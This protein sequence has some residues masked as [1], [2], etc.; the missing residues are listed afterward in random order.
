MT[1]LWLKKCQKVPHLVLDKYRPPLTVVDAIDRAVI[2]QE[3]R[4]NV[5]TILY[6]NR[7]PS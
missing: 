2:P 4:E 5:L 1:E 7:D 3:G 6:G